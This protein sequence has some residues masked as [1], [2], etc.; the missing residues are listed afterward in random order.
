MNEKLHFCLNI[1]ESPNIA[2]NFCPKTFGDIGP[3][4]VIALK[5]LLNIFFL[6]QNSRIIFTLKLF[7]ASFYAY[8]DYVEKQLKLMSESGNYLVPDSVQDS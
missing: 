5:I 6:I 2:K 4:P 1:A 3:P 7:S 8:G